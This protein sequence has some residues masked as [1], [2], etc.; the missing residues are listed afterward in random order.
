MMLMNNS[1][2]LNKKHNKQRTN[3]RQTNKTIKNKIKPTKNKTQQTPQP[4]KKGYSKT[5][6]T[7]K[8]K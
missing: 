6:K 7:S 8:P 1:E 4:P 3:K 5:I 2:I